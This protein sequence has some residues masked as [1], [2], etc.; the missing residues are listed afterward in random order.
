MN[1]ENE[2]VKGK[3]QLIA[4]KVKEE[5][6]EG[7]GFIVLAFPFGENKDNEMM[8]VS[9]ANRDDVITAMSEF[10]YKTKTSYGN[11]TGKY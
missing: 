2:K 9:N 5:L 3:M 4:K 11:D 8:Y 1:Y 10:I 7:Y 6:P